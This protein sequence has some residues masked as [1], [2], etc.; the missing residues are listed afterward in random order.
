MRN[1][2]LLTP[3]ASYG[4]VNSDEEILIIGRTMQKKQGSHCKVPHFRFERAGERPEA[5]DICSLDCHGA[6][7]VPDATTGVIQRE[8]LKALS[9]LEREK[10]QQM[11]FDMWCEAQL[12][13]GQTVRCWPQYRGNQGCKY[14][15]V[16]VEFKLIGQEADKDLV[17]YPAKILAMYEDINGEFKVLVHSVEYK[18]DRNVEGPYGDS[19]LVC[20]YHLEFNNRGDPNVFSLPFKDIVKCIVGY[21]SVKYREPLIS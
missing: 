2:T 12:P 6:E 5:N 14:N 18:T 11:I 9:D 10:S 17:P 16:L 19:R 4:A 15:W 3:P 1:D 13:N 21:E 7:K 8:V 20:H